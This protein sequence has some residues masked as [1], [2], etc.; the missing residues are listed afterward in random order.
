MP[1]IIDFGVAKATAQP[2]TDR[3]LFTEMGMLIGTP[4]YMSPEQAE[5]TGL[6]VD[7]RSDVYALGVL[8][9]ELLIGALP[10]DRQQLREAGLESIRRTIRETEP[11]RPS[12]RVTTLVAASN[13]SPRR[14]GALIA[15]GSCASSAATSTGS[16]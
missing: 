3:S 2:L 14:I 9:Y 7:T 13:R 16:P 6:D 15:R 12:R 8:L 10:F 4:E 1:R 11:P 5:M